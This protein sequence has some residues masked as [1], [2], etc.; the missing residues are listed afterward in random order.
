MR[1]AVDGGCHFEGEATLTDTRVAIGFDFISVRRQNLIA[2]ILHVAAGRIVRILEP[3]NLYQRNGHGELARGRNLATVY[4]ESR[5]TGDTLERPGA[6]RRSMREAPAERQDGTVF[7]RL[8][9]SSA[10]PAR[11][12]SGF[13]FV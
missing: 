1:N 10:R 9:E 13:D 5:D 11:G 3:G 6:R 12:Q 8:Q 7:Q 2:H 4:R